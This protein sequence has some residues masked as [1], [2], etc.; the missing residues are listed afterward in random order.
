MNHR[1]PPSPP[2]VGVHM[3]SQVHP[4]VPILLD[5]QAAA[6]VM[7]KAPPA[8]EPLRLRLAWDDG[9][10]TELCATLRRVEGTPRVH[11]AH[12]DINRVDGDWKPFL[13]YLAGSRAA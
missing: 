6:V 1:L 5:G 11:V 13:A 9:Q 3:G 2:Q 10:V 7:S 8:N 12:M 4:A